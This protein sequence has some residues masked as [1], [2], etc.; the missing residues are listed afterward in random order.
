[1]PADW[2]DPYERRAIAA[3]VMADGRYLRQIEEAVVEVRS[4]QGAAVFPGRR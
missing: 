2:R 4:A 1:M 3:D